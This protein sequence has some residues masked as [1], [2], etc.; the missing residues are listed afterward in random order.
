MLN[1]PGNHRFQFVYANPHVGGV[2]VHQIFLIYHDADVAGEENNIP[3]FAKRGFGFV[4]NGMANLLLL[5]V[6]IAV[7]YPIYQRF[8]GAGGMRLG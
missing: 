2:G 5:L 3:F 8:A 1:E 4:G 7:L 6:C